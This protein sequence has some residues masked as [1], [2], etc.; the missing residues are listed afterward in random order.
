M[1]KELLRLVLA[2]IFIISGAVKAIDA[3]GFSFKLEEYFSPPVFNM[4]F[5][6][7]FALP[8]AIF[9]VVLEL[10]L[11]FTLL[12]KIKLKPTILAMIGMCI[13]FAFL[14]FYSAYF[15]VVTDCGCFG[16]AIK[17]TP[18][19]SFWKDIVLLVLLIILWLSVK[20]TEE[21]NSKI[22]FLALLVLVIISSYIIF[23]GIKN[24]PIVDFRDYKIGT[25]LK[26]EKQKLVENP[27]I[28]TTFYIL[29]NKKTGEEKKINQDDYILD[30]SLWKEGSD[31]EIQSDKSTSEIL[32]EGYKSEIAKFRIENA[33][34]EDI[35]EEIINAPRA[36][37]VFSYKPKEVS[38]EALLKAENEALAL[39]K[40]GTIYG[41][42]TLPNVFKLL[43]NHTMDGTAI[44]TIAR[45]NPF[46][47]ILENGIVVDKR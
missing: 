22:K 29:K 24:E 2:V 30:E 17:F 38:V 27:P 15:N 23:E 26:A 5:L 41:V 18:W 32:E 16:D 19:Q 12:L 42:S 9:V 47:L 7:G 45:S 10:V 35:T 4:P 20:N 8:I 13:F 31:W 6:E 28:Y 36:V 34:G 46:I 25:N 37:L 44:K 14:T 1:L 21:K 3:K 33:N 11:G 43:P 39:Q 40:G